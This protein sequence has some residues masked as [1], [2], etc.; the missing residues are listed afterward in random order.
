MSGKEHNE[1]MHQ[2]LKEQDFLKTLPNRF[3][4]T[5]MTTMRTL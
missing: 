1:K 5:Y 4:I 2:R 3:Y